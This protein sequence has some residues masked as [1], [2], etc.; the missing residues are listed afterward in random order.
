VSIDLDAVRAHWE[1][2]H[3]EFATLLDLRLEELASGIAVMR[4]PFRIDI[5][6]GAGAVHGG[7]IASLADTAFYVA[8]ATVFSW[9]QPTVTTSIT[10]NFLAPARQGADLVARAH[11]VKGGKR[12][13]YG[14]V[15]VHG[16][17]T[18]VAHATMTYLN[19]DA[20]R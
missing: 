18:L 20:S 8:H 19:T 6:N 11:V 5:A 13:V 2:G 9:E 1:R 12:L 17:E 16:G 4:L 7:A 14:E 15:S 10:C 3:S